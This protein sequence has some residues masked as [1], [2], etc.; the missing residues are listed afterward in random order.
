LEA[1]IERI[2]K[3]IYGSIADVLNSSEF[4]T[5]IQEELDLISDGLRADLGNDEWRNHLGF[6]HL[7]KHDAS[8]VTGQGRTKKRNRILR[9]RSGNHKIARFVSRPLPIVSFDAFRFLG[10]S[11]YAINE[12]VSHHDFDVFNL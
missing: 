9:S 5:V 11:I 3:R 6:K 1:A 4:D 7:H 12:N 8:H 2:E 10:I